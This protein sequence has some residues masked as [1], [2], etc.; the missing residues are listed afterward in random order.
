MLLFPIALTMIVRKNWIV[1]FFHAS[2]TSDDAFSDVAALASLIGQANGI[3]MSRP[4]RLV[5]S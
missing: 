4:G 5:L 3:A 2:N 1:A